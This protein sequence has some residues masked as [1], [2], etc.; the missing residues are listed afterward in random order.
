MVY[1]IKGQSH[2][3]LA[4]GSWQLA[5][6][7]TRGEDEGPPMPPIWLLKSYIHPPYC[8]LLFLR[9]FLVRFWA[10]LGEGSSKTPQK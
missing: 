1:K 9:T 4:A 6:L 2:V 8:R 10:L 5:V 3:H 7:Q